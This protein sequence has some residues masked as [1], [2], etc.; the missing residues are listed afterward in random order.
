MSYTGFS[1]LNMHEVI[2]TFIC[3]S[4]R[5]FGYLVLLVTDLYWLPVAV[6]IL[7]TIF[8]SKL[9]VFSYQCNSRLVYH[10]EVS[11]FNT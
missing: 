2:F 8:H 6:L 9:S 11:E 1:W 7:L 5:T 10:L 4:T 3:I